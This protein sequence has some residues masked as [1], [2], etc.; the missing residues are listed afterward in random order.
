MAA[1]PSLIAVQKLYDLASTIINLHIQLSQFNVLIGITRVDRLTPL[2]DGR[3]LKLSCKR[4]PCQKWLSSM[5]PKLQE[6]GSPYTVGEKNLTSQRKI[7][8]RLK[9]C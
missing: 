1:L 5:H 3:V 7:H 2:Q 6:F 9:V 4:F 8:Y